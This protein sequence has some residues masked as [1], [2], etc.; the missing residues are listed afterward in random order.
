M[1]LS[2]K[3]STNLVRWHIFEKFRINNIKVTQA[4]TKFYG[5]ISL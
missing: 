5:K 3:L 1:I 2:Y 4:T